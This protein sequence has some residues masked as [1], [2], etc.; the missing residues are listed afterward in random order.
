MRLLGLAG[1]RPAPAP[2]PRALPHN[3]RTPSPIRS[4]SARPAA[5]TPVPETQQRLM[6]GA[7]AKSRTSHVRSLTYL[8][9]QGRKPARLATT[10]VSV[11]LCVP[12]LRMALLR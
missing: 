3:N 11:R 9:S 6:D 10:T 8:S 2:T 7:A 4:L 1:H 5:G 12:S